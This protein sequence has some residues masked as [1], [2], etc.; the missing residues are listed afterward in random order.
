L[1]YLGFVAVFAFCR[2]AFAQQSQ[3]F[4]RAD[5][6]RVKPPEVREQPDAVSLRL[7]A[8]GT[9]LTGN[10]DNFVLA[11]AL[12]LGVRLGARYDLFL[13]GNTNH[14]IFD[15]KPNIDKDA[16]GILYVVKLAPHWNFFSQ[17]TH[18]RNRFLT[19][20]YRGSIGGGLCFHGFGGSSFDTLLLSAGLASEYEL[21]A[22]GTRELTPRI[23]VRLTTRWPRKSD[24]F[25][26]G[27]FI[28][29]ESLRER[30]D[31]R[32]FFEAYVEAKLK[33][34]AL[35]VRVAAIEEYDSRPR[36]NVRPSDFGVVTSLV[37]RLGGA[38]D[39]R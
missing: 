33:A 37:V 30:G 38:P 3:P 19:L 34:K 20:D 13:D 15:G 27:D 10:V 8:G 6:T 25:V 2:L 26:G 31:I 9:Y 24:V 21:W 7:S 11:S 23:P 32:L 39:A 5:D 35:A 22:D 16:G 4:S 36:P 28:A 12:E 1:K 29:T 14:V 17:S 18:S